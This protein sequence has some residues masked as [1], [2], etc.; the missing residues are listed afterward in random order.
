MRKKP[1]IP[2][3]WRGI[4]GSAWHRDDR[5]ILLNVNGPLSARE[6]RELA[7]WLTR[8]AEYQDSL[9]ARKTLVAKRGRKPKGLTARRTHE[10]RNSAFRSARGLRVR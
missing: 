10:T 4:T 6:A 9:V 7:L 2:G 8:A 1:R 5:P 3:I